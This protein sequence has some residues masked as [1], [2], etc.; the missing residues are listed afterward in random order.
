M[1]FQ[2]LNICARKKTVLKAFL[3]GDGTGVGCGSESPLL[4]DQSLIKGGWGHGWG[5]IQCENHGCETFVPPPLETVS[6]LLCPLPSTLWLK[7]KF[8]VLELPLNC[9]YP[10]L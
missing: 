1:A 9:L 5:A 10:P 4:R 2:D 8:P 7:L 6:N 3:T